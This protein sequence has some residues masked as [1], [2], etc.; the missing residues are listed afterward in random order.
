MTETQ[1]LDLEPGRANP[2]GAVPA[3]VQ[4]VLFDERD[5]ELAIEEPD[6]F[7]DLDLVACESHALPTASPRFPTCA[8]TWLYCIAIC[9]Q[10]SRIF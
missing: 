5:V 1:R 2:T 7:G 9:A 3:Q 4:S 8:A 10:C 6:F